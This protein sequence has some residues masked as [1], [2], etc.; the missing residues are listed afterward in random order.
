MIQSPE[1]A[2][3][4]WYVYRPLGQTADGGFTVTI[5]ENDTLT[6][7]V[8]GEMRQ[9][10]QE[11]T[12][13]LPQDVQD[14]LVDMA[15]S[16]AWWVGQMPESMRCS[17]PPSCASMLGIAGHPMYVVEELEESAFLPF[18]TQKGHF[19]RRIFLFL[20]DVSELLSRFGFYLEPQRFSWDQQNV[21]PMMPGTPMGLY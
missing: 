15:D 1:C 7:T 2:A 12:F 8:F 5:Y 21:F 16:V 17:H 9:V 3:L 6:F 13:Q 4:F 20:E 10:L 18:A 19:A 14:E 11:L